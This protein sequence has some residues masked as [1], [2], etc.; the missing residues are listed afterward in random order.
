MEMPNIA[1]KKL[2]I[3]KFLR[4]KSLEKVKVSDLEPDPQ[5]ER[6]QP[7]ERMIGRLKDHLQS[8]RVKHDEEI[9]KQPTLKD[10]H[11]YCV[12]H[13]ISAQQYGPLLER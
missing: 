4:K 5:R 12:L 9:M 8:T 1:K 10:A 13:G 2:I 6:Q 11:I 3:V 7:K